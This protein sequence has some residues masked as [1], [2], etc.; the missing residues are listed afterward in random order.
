MDGTEKLFY[1]SPGLF[2]ADARVLAV[3]G[4]AEAPVLVLDRTI[5]YPEGGGQPCDL[6]TIG[7]VACGQEDGRARVP[8]ASVAERRSP[9]GE[10]RVLHEMS[11]PLAV[12]PGDS[13]HLSVDASRRV[14][15]SQQHSAE[16]LLGSI[17]LRL[18][19]AR[20]VSVR[21]GPERSTIDFDLPAI[22]EEEAAAIEAAADAAI[23]EDRPI[24]YRL[25]PPEDASSFPL[26]R[27]PPAGEEYLR[28]VEIEGLD[29][30]PCCGLHLQSTLG[31]RVIRVLGTEKYKGM[32][33][34]HFV[35]GRRA[36]ADYRALS[37]IARDSVR[38]LGT[39]EAHLAEAV[40][41]E[42]E[43]RKEL[44]YALVGMER[45]RAAAEAAAAPEAALAIQRDKG[46]AATAPEAA[47]AGGRAPVALRRY[48]DR[49]A[50]S[51]MTSAKAFSEAGMIALFASLPELTVQALAPSA[52]AKL[53]ERL[54]APLAAS[55]GKGGGGPATFRAVF[56]DVASLDSFM[57]GAV[58]ILSAPQ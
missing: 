23:A 20:V 14:D 32:T 17:A 26:R 22:S 42:A 50:S 28:I 7:C 52:E 3:E 38:V 13:V 10:A 18:I 43:R 5:F 55:G 39:S 35:A 47:R 54:K 1:E 49:S 12:L 36:T 6:G 34:L 53:G 2:E 45:G 8:V 21:F 37:R 40:A 44:E 15:Y 4:K 58:S 11:G 57:D 29:F 48:A 19:G 51:L 41:H 9:G 25:C 27:Q 24:R 30:S 31:L 16:H 33:R 46:A 56:K